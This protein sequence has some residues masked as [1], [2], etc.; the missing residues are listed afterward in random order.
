[1]RTGKIVKPNIQRHRCTVIVEGFGKR[2][3]E[4]SESPKV[5]SH[6]E[7]C[8]FDMRGRDAGKIRSANFDS[9]D[10]PQNPA[11][12]CGRAPNDLIE[13]AMADSR[14]NKLANQSG[15]GFGAEADF[16]SG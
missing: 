5:H 7:V 6:G 16:H 1:M 13:D 3:C 11:T 9:W 15:R 2:I 4:P 12:A 8:A 10:R 14:L